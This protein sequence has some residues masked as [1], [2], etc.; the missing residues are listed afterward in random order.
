M[1]LFA[2]RLSRRSGSWAWWRSRWSRSATCCYCCWIARA[3]WLSRWMRLWLRLRWLLCR[4][5]GIRCRWPDVVLLQASPRWRLRVWMLL[6]RWGRVSAFR[7]A[8]SRHRP[9]SCR[10]QWW[11]PVR[12]G[13]QA[14]RH[15]GVLCLLCR[16]TGLWPE[17]SWGFSERWPDLPEPERAVL[18]PGRAG[19]P[20][21]GERGPKWCFCRRALCL[22]RRRSARSG[23]RL[24]PRWPMLVPGLQRPDREPGQW[25]RA[26]GLYALAGLRRHGLLWCC[27][28][29]SGGLQC[30]F[31]LW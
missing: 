8:R 18:W 25:W 24:M 9:E 20:R 26:P 11:E 7:W 13:R 30:R 15:A 29:P 5:W 21:S 28:W 23:R 19:W 16:R 27:R 22:S 12:R 6:R 2:A 10:W 4:G 3:Q 17:C 31:Y 14:H 1:W